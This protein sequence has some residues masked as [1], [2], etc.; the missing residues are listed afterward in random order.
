MDNKVVTNKVKFFKKC[1]IELSNFLKMDEQSFC[2][3]SKN[4]A[5]SQT[6]LYGA[7]QTSVFLAAHTIQ[8]CNFE[9]GSNY[10]E[11]F[12]ILCK[13][14]KL[15]AKNLDKYNSLLEIRNR[16]IFNYDEITGEY[17]Y[18]VIFKNLP[19]LSLFLKDLHKRG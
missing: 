13:N 11:I 1:I 7:I 8:K 3:N 16:L 15:D 18:D 6:F 19:I 9:N 14:G 17:M 2:N 4:V 12:S 5:A 10:Y